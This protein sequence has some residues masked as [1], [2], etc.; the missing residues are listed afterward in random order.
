MSEIR[1]SHMRYASAPEAPAGGSA[2]GSQA[3]QNRLQ[4]RGAH[5]AAG[6]VRHAQALPALVQLAGDQ[7]AVEAVADQQVLQLA[8]VCYVQRRHEFRIGYH[9]A[10]LRMMLGQDMKLRSLHAVTAP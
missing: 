5:V 4:V 6:S 9:L 3:I 7:A 10:T 8:Y 2:P 1:C